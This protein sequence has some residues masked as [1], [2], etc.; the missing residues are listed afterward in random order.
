MGFFL[1]KI[2]RAVPSALIKVGCAKTL[3]GSCRNCRQIA[4]LFLPV[5]DR[6]GAASGTP[7]DLTAADDEGLK[8]HRGGGGAVAH[9]LGIS[10][11]T[12]RN[13]VFIILN[14]IGKREFSARQSV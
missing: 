4:Q 10:E 12:I 1:D 6:N 5:R 8:A 9:R 14:K 3:V 13:S 2:A 7:D 11:K